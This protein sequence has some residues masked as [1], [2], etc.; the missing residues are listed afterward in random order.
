MKKRTRV[1]VLTTTLLFTIISAAVLIELPGCSP[2]D[3]GDFVYDASPGAGA[4]GS[5]S[6]APR[7]AHVP[8]VAPAPADVGVIKQ[9]L[10]ECV[11]FYVESE[12]ADFFETRVGDPDIQGEVVC[13]GGPLYYLDQTWNCDTADEHYTVVR[14]SPESELA[15][16]TR[17]TVLPTVALP[18]S[19]RCK[20]DDQCL[21]IKC[22]EI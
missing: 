7:E 1:T 3:E 15:Y 17:R 6:V 2:V 19:F 21:R 12:A 11:S 9:P 8:I 16:E 22:E 10:A 13:D 14:Y 4:A 20:Y 18:W 5:V